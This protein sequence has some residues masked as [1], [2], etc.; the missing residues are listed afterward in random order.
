MPVSSIG[1]GDAFNAGLIS[2]LLEVGDTGTALEQG[3]WKVEATCWKPLVER[4]IAFASDVCRALDN[5][6]SVEFANQMK[7]GQ[8][9]FKIHS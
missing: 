8:M 7:N 2:G 3:R 5:S 9:A 1:A 4:A 6:I